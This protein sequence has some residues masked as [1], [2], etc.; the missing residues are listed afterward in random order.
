MDPGDELVD[1][2]D[3]EDCVID[4][5]PRREIRAR[6]LLHR[7]TYVLVR[8]TEDLI[9]VHRRADTKAVDP[10]VYDMFAGGVC[11]AGESYDD[12]ARR[13]VAEELG[14]DGVEPRRL[15][16]HRYESDNGRAWGMVYDVIWSG[17]IRRQPEEVAW[18]AWVSPG[19]L[20]RMLDEFAF[21]EDSRQIYERL[22]SS[23]W[24]T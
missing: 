2:V 12:C 24:S 23:T 20:G 6:N 10:G 5:V 14:V 18:S 19:E 4:V 8:G 11:A 16:K 7:C 1:I 9:V 15:F 17:E 3:E 21:C 22:R 13:E